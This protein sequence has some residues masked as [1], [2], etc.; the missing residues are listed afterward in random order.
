MRIERNADVE[1]GHIAVFDEAEA[2]VLSRSTDALQAWVGAGVEGA[3][4]RIRCLESGLTR[5]EAAF[6]DEGTL[7]AFLS[8]FLPG[9]ASTLT[10][11]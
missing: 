8:R 3:R 6:P 11:A 10:F 5:I 2:R 4:G 7:R 1:L 9:Q